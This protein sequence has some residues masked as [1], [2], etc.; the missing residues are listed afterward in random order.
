MFVDFTSIINDCHLVFM[1]GY[2]NTL[3]NHWFNPFVLT[4]TLCFKP[5]TPCSISLYE[6]KRLALSNWLTDKQRTVLDSLKTITKSTVGWVT[7]RIVI[8]SETPKIEAYLVQNTLPDAYFKGLSIKT[9]YRWIYQGWLEN[10]NL[11]VLRHKFH[12]KSSSLKKS[13]WLKPQMQN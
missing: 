5:R 3:I 6:I 10:K 9:I 4:I 13:F 8:L 1:L 7:W 12:Y 11:I 2:V